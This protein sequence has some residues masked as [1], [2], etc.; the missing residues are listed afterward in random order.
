MFCE[1]LFHACLVEANAYGRSFLLIANHFEP[2]RPL[3]AAPT[4]IGWAIR[5]YG[6]QAPYLALA[7]I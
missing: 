5:E 7:G 4:V 3:I 1:Y 2:R 6:L